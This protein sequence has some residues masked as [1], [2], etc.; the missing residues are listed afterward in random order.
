ML[1][2][3]MIEAE[4]TLE[5]FKNLDQKT[6]NEPQEVYASRIVGNKA[7]SDCC[8]SCCELEKT[9]KSLNEENSRLKT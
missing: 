7:K 9:V 2:G 8:H 3:P 6:I 1:K 4:T 5:K